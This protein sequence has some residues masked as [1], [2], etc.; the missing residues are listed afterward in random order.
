MGA[1]V[2]NIVTLLSKDFLRLVVL[3][4]LIASPPAW[5]VMNKWLADFAFKT[6]IEWWIFVL[7]GIMAISIALSTVSFKAIRAVVVN[8]VK[9][10]QSE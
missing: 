2:A 5:F 4:I 3:A 10:L 9:S 8:P 7:S 1:T 6:D